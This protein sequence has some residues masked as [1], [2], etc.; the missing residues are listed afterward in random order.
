MDT[1]PKNESAIKRAAM[2]SRVGLHLRR[3]RRTLLMRNEGWM[4]E[5]AETSYIPPAPPLRASS[6]W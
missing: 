4:P 1:A 3:R 5:I 6:S 2:S